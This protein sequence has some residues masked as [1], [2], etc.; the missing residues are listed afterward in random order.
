MKVIRP[1]W[2][3]FQNIGAKRPSDAKFATLQARN[4][5]ASRVSQLVAA[6]KVNHAEIWQQCVQW[7]ATPESAAHAVDDPISDSDADSDGESTD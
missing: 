2:E 5:E 7:A 6:T 4:T 3:R 1:S